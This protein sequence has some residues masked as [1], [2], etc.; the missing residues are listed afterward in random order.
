MLKLVLV[1]LACVTVWSAAEEAKVA[2]ITGASSGIGL[3]TAKHLASKGMAVVLTARRT[4][5]LQMAVK[6]I[7]ETGGKA[8]Y[9]KLD[10]TI[11]EDQ[12]AAFKA[13]KE[14]FG[15]VDYVFINAGYEG[16]AVT[17]LEDADLA[18]AKKVFDINVWGMLA[19]MKYG[20]L[21][22]KERGG[23]AMVTVSSV[24]GTISSDAFETTGMT[25]LGAYAM[26]KAATD[27]QGRLG[28]AYLKDGIRVYN[29]KPAVYLSEMPARFPGGM[30]ALSGFNP[31]FK[32]RIGDPAFLAEVVES[33]FTGT[34]LWQPGQNIICDGDATFDSAIEYQKLETI[35]AGNTL[36][37]YKAAFRSATGGPYKC[38]TES[39]CA[40][41]NR[42]EEL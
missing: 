7:E 9:T 28:K 26:S 4:D 22:L 33:M 24:A 31:V 30:E 20:V 14:A 19:T 42:K 41:F 40:I 15:G 32:G 2:L 12:I 23:G 36:A 8:M 17:P 5:K 37:E 21:A 25:G 35:G 27:M 18:Q 1:T 6:E 3:A 16:D 39:S 11:E 13:A 34:T 29:I 38:T 10:V